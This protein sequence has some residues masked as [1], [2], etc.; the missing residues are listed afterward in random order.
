MNM[1]LA[2]CKVRRT[3]ASRHFL[4]NGGCKG[5]RKSGDITPRSVINDLVFRGIFSFFMADC[6]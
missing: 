5:E 1:M 3:A 4:G 2:T 6:E